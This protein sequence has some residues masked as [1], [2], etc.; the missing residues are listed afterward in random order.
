MASFT[1]VQKA[2]LRERGI[3]EDEAGRQLSLIAAPVTHADLVRPC[4]LEDGVETIPAERQESLIFLHEEAS[5][6]GRCSKFVPAAGAAT[7][8]FQDVLTGQGVAALLEAIERLAFADDVR[9]EL[10]F[11]GH[12][13]DAL[14]DAGSGAEVVDA[15]LGADGLGYATIPKGLI[16]F[17]RY[18]SAARTAFEEHLVEA[19]GYVRD[20][21][22]TC[23]IHFTVSPE[24]LHAFRLLAERVVPAYERSLDARFDLGFS[25]QRASTDTIAG[26]PSGG[27]FV[28]A[29]GRLVLR[30]SGHGALLENLAELSGDIVFI[31]NID[32]VQTDANRGDTLRW[33][34][35][36][37]G[38]LVELQREVFLHVA[39]LRS[40]PVDA[41]FAAEASEFAR[42]K[43]GVEARGDTLLR[44][45]ERPLRVCGVVR[46]TG[47]PGGG[48]YWVRGRDG[49]ITRQIVEPVQ[50][51]LRLEPQR[52]AV[53]ASTHFNPVDLVCG[54]LDVSGAPFDLRAFVDPR[55]GIVAKK[56]HQGRD[57]L[58]LERP[59]LWNGAMA[60]WIT[61]FVE[62]PLSTF[63]PVKTVVDLLRPEHQ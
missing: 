2:Q 49:R 51:D 24:H 28:A 25:V 20:A 47:E 59:G 50:V 36:L 58:A 9:A 22:R 43:L 63:T 19:A 3:S 21:E 26:M 29:D 60:E 35:V 18:A 30:P 27:P 46:N 44:L 34:R 52:A 55:A 17:H 41:A 7:R 39:R 53:L 16:P 54:V 31:K 10:A 8:M 38:R 4:R 45:L 5:R 12:D 37:G 1:V 61:V 15:L 62:V 42:A 57:L 6:Q 48:P 56:S 23:R 40:R 14:R 32:N 13:L 11:R 33:K